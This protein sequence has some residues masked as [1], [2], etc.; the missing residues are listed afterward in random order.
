MRFY[1]GMMWISELVVGMG[2]LCL[3]LSGYL[4]EAIEAVVG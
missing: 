2:S 1:M 3:I 4:K